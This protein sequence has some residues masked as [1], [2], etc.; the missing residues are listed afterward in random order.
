MD[1]P[2]RLQETDRGAFFGR[3]IPARASLLGLALAVSDGQKG[4][5][6]QEAQKVF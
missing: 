3:R 6:F 4:K 1:A 2:I 5:L